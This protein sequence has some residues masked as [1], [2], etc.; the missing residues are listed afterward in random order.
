[1]KRPS[2]TAALKRPI[3]EPGH[4]EPRALDTQITVNDFWYRSAMLSSKF[5]HRSN[6]SDEALAAMRVL[7]ALEAVKETVGARDPSNTEDPCLS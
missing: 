4:Y 5:V 2:I 6:F 7:Q 3:T 1:M